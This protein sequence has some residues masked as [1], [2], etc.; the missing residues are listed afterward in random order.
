[1]K[2]ALILPYDALSLLSL[3]D[4]GYQLVLPHLC[5]E[6]Q[7]YFETYRDL[8]GFKIMDNGAA[9]GVEVYHVDLHDVAISVGADEIVVP[10]V[11]GDCDGTIA[12]VR[13]FERWARPDQFQYAG[14]VQGSNMAEIVKCLN[15]YDGE[16]WIS[17]VHIPRILNRVIHR[18]FRFT[19]LEALFGQT[20]SRYQYRFDH[21]H[22]LGASEWIRECSALASVPIVRGMDTSLLASMAIARR[23]IDMPDA[24]Y[25]Q[26]QPDFFN[27]KINRSSVIWKVLCGNIERYLNWAG[28]DYTSRDDEA[29]SGG[30]V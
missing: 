10:D 15:F 5:W 14:V 13:S 21:I 3:Y 11:L 6:K 28:C 18:T 22:C 17:N 30:E 2:V 4:T 7:E 23:P 8:G 24:E 20:G 16:E 26:R 1:M 12:K 19:F 9:E 27:A 25:V 29:S